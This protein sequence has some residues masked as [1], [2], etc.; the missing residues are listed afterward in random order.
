[1]TGAEEFQCKAMLFDLDGVLVDSRI[2]V[3]RTWRR[4]AERHRIDAE[5]LLRIAHGRRTRDTVEA[6]APHLDLEA[7]VAWLEG[8]ELEDVAD[9][10]VVPGAKRLL[11]ALPARAWAVVTSGGRSLARRRLEAM[12]LPVP[13]VLI[14]SEAVRQGKPAPDGYRMAAQHLGLEPASCVA[15]EDTPPG[16]AAAR[17]AG[18]RVIALTTT[19]SAQQLADADAVIR[20]FAEVSVRTNPAG[21]LLSIGAA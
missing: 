14:T 9:L 16:V 5:P 12:G 10:A 4:W 1:M 6:V 8:A 3:E 17:G 20:D 19:H 11:D 7:E 2:V 21:L 13:P 18:A 15:F